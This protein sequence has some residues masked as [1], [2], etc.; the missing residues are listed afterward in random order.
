MILVFLL[1]VGDLELLVILLG[2]SVVVVV[3]GLVEM[4]AMPMVV[5]LEIAEHQGLIHVLL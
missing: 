2:I 1:E 5:R 3:V 4:E